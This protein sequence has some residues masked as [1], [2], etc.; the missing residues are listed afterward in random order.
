MTRVAAA[1]S[2]KAARSG[3]IMLLALFLAGLSLRPQLVGIGPLLPLI[4]DDLVVTHAIAGLLVTIPVFCMAASPLLAPI[5]SEW[6]DLRAAVVLSLA[7]L[8]VGGFL[9]AVAPDMS[10]IL[11]ISLVVGVGLG[12]AGALLPVVV[13]EQM[14]DRPAVE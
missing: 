12:V 5:V 10:L 14:V 8:A 3:G 13:G 2:G 9:R 1:T 4:Q 6:L 11:L 7:V